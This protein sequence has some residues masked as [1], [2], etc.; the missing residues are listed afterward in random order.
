MKFA[1]LFLVPAATMAFAPTQPLRFP[2]RVSNVALY[3]V[4]DD[5]DDAVKKIEDTT[6]DY[7]AKADD[8]VLN[9]GMRIANHFPILVTLKALADKAGMSASASGITAVSISS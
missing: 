7:V 4:R 8:L 2:T 5:F 9:R 6:E 3:D 1:I